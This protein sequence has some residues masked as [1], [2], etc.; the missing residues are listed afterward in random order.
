LCIYSNTFLRGASPPVNPRP[1][2]LR[3][4][5]L[6]HIFITGFL[7]CH[8]FLDFYIYG[9]LCRRLPRKPSCRRPGGL[10][11]TES[12]VTHLNAVGRGAHGGQSPL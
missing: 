6:W 4:A 3:V 7:I 11:G 12:P 9:L 2:A 1:T 5:C 8:S 10:R